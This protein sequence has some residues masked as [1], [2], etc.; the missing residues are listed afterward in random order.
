MVT[1]LK[2]TKGVHPVELTCDEQGLRIEGDFN[3]SQKCKLTI[4]NI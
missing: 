3:A 1:T 2:V 4:Y